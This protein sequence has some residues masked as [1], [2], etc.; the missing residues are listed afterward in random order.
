[1]GRKLD[2]LSVYLDRREKRK[3]CKKERVTDISLS[4]SENHLKYDARKKLVLRISGDF[5]E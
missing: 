1:M 5:G 4:L 3:K 2:S